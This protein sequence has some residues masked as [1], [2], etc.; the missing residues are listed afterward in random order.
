MESNNTN[1]VL[2]T[3]LGEED[4]KRFS[5]LHDK[6]MKNVHAIAKV[7]QEILALGFESSVMINMSLKPYGHDGH[8]GILNRKT[9]FYALPLKS[10]T[11]LPDKPIC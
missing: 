6:F 8:T 1:T 11:N 10:A 7:Q 9:S 4:Q 2:T 3:T 5:A